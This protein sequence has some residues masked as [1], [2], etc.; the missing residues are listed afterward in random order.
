M[1][2]VIESLS[3]KFISNISITLQA[4]RLLNILFNIINEA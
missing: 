4:L 2:Y 3:I 1:Y